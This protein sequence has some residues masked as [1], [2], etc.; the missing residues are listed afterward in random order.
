MKFMPVNFMSMTVMMTSTLMVLSSSSWLM[1]WVALELNMFSFLPMMKLESKYYED[2]SMIKYFIFQSFASSLMLFSIMVMFMNNLNLIEFIFIM[3]ILMKL[4]SFPCYFWFPSVMNGLNW[5]SCM[6]LSTWQKLAPLCML[7]FYIGKNSTM[8]FISL[9]NILIGGMFGLFQSDLRILMAYSSIS[10]LGWIMSILYFSMKFI[11]LLYFFVYTILI[12]P[13][14]ILLNKFNIMNLNSLNKNSSMI[15]F[16]F[17]MMFLSLAGLPP[18][19]GFFPKLLMI[20]S[21]VNFSMLMIIMMVLLS[22]LSLYMYLNVV[23]LMMFN[24]FKTLKIMKF[25]NWVMIAIMIS[26]MMMPIVMLIYAVI[27]LN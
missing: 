21:M 24:M 25:N 19:S 17:I 6:I 10:H 26:V 27:F 4:G 11:S 18:L 2:E 13:I 14:F 8:L 22:M 15:V 7:I 20:Y 5:F 12:I 1:L 16:S 3:S 9:M 23:F